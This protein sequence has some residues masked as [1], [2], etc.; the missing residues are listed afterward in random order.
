[1][2]VT[3]KQKRDFTQGKVLKNMLLFA[4]PIALASILQ[5]FF[6]SADVAI[7][8]Q[9]GGSMYQAAVGAT[10]STVHLIVNLFVGLSGGVNVAMAIAYGSK[11][12]KRQHRV[13]H[14][15]MAT[16][17]VSGIITLLLGVFLS[18]LLL[19]AIDTPADILEYSVLYMQIYFLG[20]PAMMIYNFGAALLRSVGETKKPLFYLLIAGIVNLV[21]NVITVLFFHW[22]VV[23]VAL[24]TVFSQVV[25][26]VWVV[27][28]LCKNKYGVHYQIRKTRFYKKE[29]KKILAMGVPMGLNG[30]FFAVSNLLI[31]SSINAYGGMAIAGNT[32]AVNIEAFGDSFAGAVENAAVTFV[33]QNVGAGK[34]ERVPRILGA[35]LFASLILQ[36]FFSAIYFLV[37]KYL[38]MLFNSDPIVIDWALKRLFVVGVTYVV[39]TLMRGYGSALKGMG[40]SLSP[41]LATLFFTC[42]VRVFYVLVIYSKFSVKIIQYIYILYPITWIL[43]GFC[44]M[45]IFYFVWARERK[46]PIL[47]QENAQSTETTE[48][49]D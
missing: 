6:N 34:T 15:A 28:D 40:H 44:L 7:V 24:G 21:V 23:G 36:L 11:D 3:Q 14:T 18:R 2:H 45:G 39:T 33:G 41:M 10:T 38:C 4:L 42:V 8:G 35:C 19:V 30:A 20:A 16:A 13:T 37:G 46:T 1:M 47:K 32:V 27:R 26:A 48:S 12:E 43:T 9:F 22:H 31:Q 17:I 5:I 25:A 49:Q 29:F